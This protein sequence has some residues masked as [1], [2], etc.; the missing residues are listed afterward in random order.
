MNQIETRIVKSPPVPPGSRGGQAV[1]IIE[2]DLFGSTGGGQ[3]VYQKIISQRPDDTFYYFVRDEP[4]DLARPPNAIAIPFREMWSGRSER[5]SSDLQWMLGDY[6]FCR[7][8]AA[9]AKE[10]GAPT[11]FD[12]VDV[13]DFRPVGA[14]IRPAF[15]AEGVQIGVVALAMHGTLSSAF[16]LGWPDGDQQRVLAQLRVKERLQ[17]RVA[18]A[19]Y[20]ISHRYSQQW[21]RIAPRQINL[22]DPL[23]IVARPELHASP[24]DQRSPDLAFFGR[25]EKW[26]GPDLFLDIAWC[27]DPSSYNRLLLIG[28]DG[29]NR[30]GSGSL[31]VIESMARLRGLHPEIIGGLPRAKVAELFQA[32]TLLLLPSRYDTFNLASLEAI[33]AGCPI[34][35]SSH[36]GIAD[37]LSRHLPELPWL[38]T[39][40]DCSRQAAASV[41]T[42]L[43]DYDR[44]RDALLEQITRRRLERDEA[45]L[46]DIY[47]PEPQ[48]DRQARQTAV[49]IAGDLA[50]AVEQVQ[51]APNPVTHQAKGLLSGSY[52]LTRRAVGIPFR[53]IWQRLPPDL[54]QRSHAV[55]KSVRA[56]LTVVRRGP[57]HPHSRFLV[58]SEIESRTGL[59]QRSISQLVAARSLADVHRRILTDHPRSA[60]DVDA[61]LRW[62]SSLVA[63]RLIDRVTLFREMAQ[64]ERRR[65]NTLVAVTYLLRTMRWLGRDMRGDLPYVM[66]SLRELGYLAEAEAAEAMFGTAADTNSRCL[67]LMQDAL[68]RNRT[69]P[70]LPLAVREDFRGSVD[71]RVS[72][73]VSLYNAADKLPTLLTMLANQSLARAGAVEVVL[74]DSNSPANEY[75]ALKAFLA[76]RSLPVLYARSAER[77]TIQA[78]WNRGIRLS[79]APYLAFLG[80]DE[81]LHPDA[82]RILAGKLDDHR[83]VDWVM[84][85]SIVTNVDH[86]GIYDSDVMP[87][88]R[89]G[90]RQDLVYLDTTY[91]SWVGGLYRRSMHDR[92]GWYDDSYRAAGDTE[93]KNRLLPFI[94]SL[95]VPKMLGVF[96]N[97]PEERTTASPRA[98]LEDLRAW[99]LWRTPG[100]MDYALSKR[101]VEDAVALFKTC[102]RYRKAFCGHWSTDFDLAHSVAQHLASR[103][104]AGTVG[105]AALREMEATVEVM[106]S[107]ELW[108]D[109][110]SR[111]PGQLRA[112]GWMYGRFRR[113]RQLAGRHR[114]EFDLVDPPVYDAF[115]DNR[116]EQHWW[117]WSNG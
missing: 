41:E 56:G 94:R 1:L 82:L 83:D 59:S 58:K 12:V 81:G 103:D 63:T 15:A 100:G 22:F 28:P 80:A 54:R 35:A 89:I 105:T 16:R 72:V 34:V 21:Q 91:L 52:R 47:R 18:D 17:F 31:P 76:A 117:S 109:P 40:L 102:L 44:H 95:H 115:N 75:A 24:R 43:K 42:V 99:Y 86:D 77:E 39:D 45:S 74:I 110:G 50:N 69:K 20:A 101:P 90:Y 73:I 104:D 114:A 57:H 4:R 71:P 36:A 78:A 98:E 32:R 2:F 55:R 53:Q 26:K 87:Y 108:R 46:Q 29:P 97:Y 13:P 96:N 67:A 7:N 37:W 48:V 93:F 107:L 10:A 64:L 33:M 116:F 62:L 111:D 70:D 79:Q 92:F 19:R 65:G 6:V 27:V 66:S 84:A 112:I 38:L 113:L 23:W 60:R 25:R 9:S 3:T 88:D 106:R 14:F 49:E 61:K 8:F 11:A 85:D 51:A 68:S 5:V 30:T